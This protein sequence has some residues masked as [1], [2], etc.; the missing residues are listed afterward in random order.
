MEVLGL[1]DG[2]GRGAVDVH[3]QRIQHV[4]GRCRVLRKLLLQHGLDAQVHLQ[5]VLGDQRD[6]LAGS[7]R[8]RGSAHTV[9]VRLGVCGDVV[10]D[11]TV[12]GGDVQAA[13][14]DVGGDQDVGLAGLELV[15]RAQALGLGQLAV[16]RHR[17]KAQDARQERGALGVGTGAGEDDDGL[18]DKLVEQVHQVGVLVAVAHQHHGLHQV[19]CGLV[20]GG[21]GDAHRAVE[22]GALQLLDLVGHGGGEEEG[23]ALAWDHAQDLVELRAE[24]EVQQPVRLVHD[25]ILEVLQAE[26]LGVL[27]VVHNT[28]GRGHQHVRLAHQV[29]GLVHHVHA[30]HD[31]AG[32]EPHSGA[33]RIERL[34]DLVRQ[35]ARGRQHERV[36]RKLGVPQRLQDGNGERG[37]LARAGHGKPNHVF[38]LQ[39]VGDGLGLDGRG[40]GKIHALDGL[41]ELGNQLELGEPREPLASGGHAD[42]RRFGHDGG[43]ACGLVRRE[44]LFEGVFLDF[45]RERKRVGGVR[46]DAGLFGRVCFGHG[47]VEKR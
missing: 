32:A 21:H 29:T 37:G 1:L 7:A 3:M 6:G 40:L 43:A 14:G 27:Q 4:F 17:R 19:V 5:V 20:L 8:T 44:L 46:V 10:V 2:L 11:D 18:T 41:Q 25:K 28:P 15:Q 47:G 23:V 31:T 26:A 12:D 22:R 33:E 42:V 35:L 9:D 13:G 39:R 16:Q 34:L 36:V 24:V 30:A 38:S 45:V